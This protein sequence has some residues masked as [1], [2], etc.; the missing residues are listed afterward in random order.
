LRSSETVNPHE[1]EDLLA[2]HNLELGA[3]ATGQS[4]L[5]DELCLGSSDPDKVQD[6]VKRLKGHIG[7]AARFGSAVIIGGIRGKF[8]GTQPEMDQQYDQAVNAVRICADEAEKKDIQLLIEPVNRYETNFINS[9]EE[10]VAFINETGHPELK[11]LLDTFHMNI[12]EADMIKTLHKFA[13]HIG[14]IHFADSNRQA[15]GFGQIPF[16]K[17]LSALLAQNYSG[18]ITAEILPLP[19]DDSAIQQAGAFFSSLVS[20]FPETESEPNID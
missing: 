3:I 5:H 12:E 20:T 18:I 19:D 10:G 6:A 11:L 16:R 14:Y 13:D 17:I 9:A 1:L 7:L 8:S 15:P 2:K 4:C